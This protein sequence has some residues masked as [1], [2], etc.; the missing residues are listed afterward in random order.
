MLHHRRETHSVP[1]ILMAGFIT[2]MSVLYTDHVLA[3]VWLT[4][5]LVLAWAAAI[6]LFKIKGWVDDFLPVP[7]AVA[8]VWFPDWLASLGLPTFP[9]SV[10]PAAVVIGMLVHLAGDVVTK[11][12]CPIMW[13]LS[14]KGFSLKLFKAGGVIERLVIRPLVVVGTVWFG[15]VWIMGMMIVT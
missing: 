3:R 12:K 8:I 2:Y 13:P 14:S 6:R 5:V 7:V 4:L 11:Q 1:G 10:L 15:Y 9:L